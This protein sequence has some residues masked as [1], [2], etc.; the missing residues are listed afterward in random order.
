MEGKSSSTTVEQS[1]KKRARQ[2]SADSSAAA[3]AIDGD[4]A[5]IE[6]PELIYFDGPGR[7]EM[8]RL[9]FAAGRV[10]Y[11]DRR[12]SAAEFGRLKAD[13]NT[14]VSQRFGS[15]PVLRH[16]SL[17]LA[18]SS[19]IVQYAADLG[20]NAHISIGQRAVDMQYVGLHAELQTA[21]YACLFG[22]ESVKSAAKAKLPATA[23]RL[24][25]AVERMLP[26]AGGGQAGSTFV[27]GGR[28][29][30]LGDIVLFDAVTSRFP[31]LVALGI[32]VSE[33]S[34]PKLDGLVKAVRAFPPVKSYCDER[35]F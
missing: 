25:G 19:A 33:A 24:L 16:G 27:N 1:S 9:A 12:L 17:T 23:T 10:E 18:Q 30:T 32:D 3:A 20:I 22:S 11:V 4:Q 13:P 35:G 14:A 31:G 2:G 21:M 26:G 29:P 28:A 15:L 7:A 34:Y 5:K 8:S 6:P